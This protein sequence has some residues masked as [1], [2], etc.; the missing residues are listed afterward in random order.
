[1]KTSKFAFEINWPLAHG[2]G[3]V[4]KSFGT[5]WKISE[6]NYGLLTLES[7]TDVG[8]RVNV[9]PANL[10]WKNNQTHKIFVGHGKNKKI[11]K[12]RPFKKNQKL[13]NTGL[14]LFRTVEYR[15]WPFVPSFNTRVFPQSQKFCSL[16]PSSIYSWFI[17]L[18]FLLHSEF[19]SRGPG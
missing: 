15:L 9:A 4:S 14:R 6:S 11:D 17:K 19:K 8:Q 7:G 5:E 10:C 13:I 1:M 3:H 18:L 2:G 16:C 12:R